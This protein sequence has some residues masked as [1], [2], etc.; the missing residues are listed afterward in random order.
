MDYSKFDYIIIGAGAAGLQ[1]ALK[2]IE[3][4]Y[5]ESCTIGI[6]DKSLKVQNDKAWSYW[7]KGKGKWDHLIAKSWSKGLFY[8]SKKKKVLDLDSYTYK[9]L[10]SIDFYTYALDKIES[11]STATFIPVEVIKTVEYKDYVDVITSNN[12]YQATH[13]FDSRIDPSFHDTKNSITLLQHFKGIVIETEQPSFDDNVFTMMDYRLKRPNTT[14]FTYVLPFSPR[15]ALVE[16]TYFTPTL[17][18]DYDEWTHS[19]IQE[20]LNIDKYSILEEEGGIIPMSNFKFEKTHSNKISKIGT[21]GGWVKPSTGYSFKST[22]RFINKLISNI[23]KNRIPHHNLIHK[24]HRFYDTILLDV[25]YHHNEKGEEIFEKFYLRNSL[26][27]AFDFLDDRSSLFTDIKI[28]YSLASMD[29]I[30]AFFKR[31]T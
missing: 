31:F 12:N 10:R 18:K 8:S 1:L 16:F 3:D 15:R 9:T 20:I 28:M 22:D 23:K 11:S 17:I 30:K 7:E 24:R 6:L 14:S 5:F 21:A 26:T 19:Y 27:D 25:L 4:N 13:V 2:L 29:F